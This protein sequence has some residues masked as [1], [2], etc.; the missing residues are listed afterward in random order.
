[1]HERLAT[2]VFT[3][4]LALLTGMMLM[5]SVPLLLLAFPD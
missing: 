5:T 3:R 4:L 2:Y 1:M